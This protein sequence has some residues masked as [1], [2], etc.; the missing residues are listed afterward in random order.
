[1]IKIRQVI[2][3]E[4][5]ILPALNELLIDAVHNGAS[6]GFL[7]PLPKDTAEQYWQKVFAS[8]ND[9]LALW[10]AETDGKI[11]GSVQIDPC[12]KQNGRHRAELQKLFVLKGFRGQGVASQLMATADSFACENKITLLVLDTILGSKAES[13]Y[14]YLGWQRVGEIPQYAANPDGQ[15][16]A[17]VYFYKLLA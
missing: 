17:T 12:Q 8:L 13:L 14:Q 3:A 11:I 7:A 1:M 6:V 10:V 15:L 5:E 16:A 2:K 4:P 9:S